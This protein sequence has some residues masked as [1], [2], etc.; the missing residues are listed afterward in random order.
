MTMGK[1]VIRY[2]SKHAELPMK[3]IRKSGRDTPALHMEGKVD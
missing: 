3:K 2:S 1:R